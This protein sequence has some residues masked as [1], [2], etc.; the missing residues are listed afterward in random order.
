LLK[1]LRRY[2]AAGIIIWVP[3]IVTVLVIRFLVN[4]MDRS[5]LLLP[6]MYRPDALLGF[7]IPGLGVLLTIV[8]L[9]VTGTLGA[10]LFGSRIVG[11][12]ESLMSRIPLV[13]SIYSGAKQVAE[14]LLSDGSTSFK[15]VYLV[16][17]PRKG[18]WS[19]CFQTSTSLQ[20][21]QGRTAEEVICVFVPTTP[22]P[23]SGFIL[24]VPRSELI[25][26]DMSV[27]EGLKM[28]ISLGVVVPRWRSPEAAR[29]AAQE[30]AT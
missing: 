8:V 7:H 6:P 17:Y 27:D 12:W 26:L 30:G 22:N 5:L 9:L 23:T 19:M 10:N 28:I 20:E 3:L 25:E 1:T 18:V 15:R 29:L 16:Q 13:R 2:L 21:I 24:F 4:L 14:T 11:F